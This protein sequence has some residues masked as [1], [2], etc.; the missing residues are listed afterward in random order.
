MTPR[1]GASRFTLK[2]AL[3][4]ILLVGTVLVL[5]YSDWLQR[6]NWL[7]YD[8]LL[9][10]DD[11]E[12]DEDIIIVAID[13]RSLARLGSWPW[14]RRVHGDLLRILSAG[15]ARA[16]GFDILFSEMVETD[17]ESDKAFV[18]AVRENGRVLLPVAAE[19][20]SASGYIT[21]ILPFP[22]LA[23]A[24][25][26]LGHTDLEL[27]SDSQARYVFLKAGIQTPRWP[28]LALAMLQLAE[29]DED[30]LSRQRALRAGLSGGAN[31]LAWSRDHMVGIP[32]IGPP[33][34]FARVSYLDVLEGKIPPET[35]TD[36]IV[37][38]GATATGLGEALPT[39][40][41]G[42]LEPMP[43]VEIVANVLQGLRSQRTVQ[44]L[45]LGEQLFASAVVFVLLWSMS[46]YLVRHRR[47]LLPLLLVPVPMLI[48]AMIYFLARRWFEP[49][50]SM[51]VLAFTYPI[52]QW[53]ELTQL[54]QMFVIE[55]RRAAGT[56][57]MLTEAIVT[58]DGEGRIS[59]LNPAAER[60]LG[61]T[62]D[63]SV[64]RPYDQIISAYDEERRRAFRFPVTRDEQTEAPKYW[65]LNLR[66]GT[67]KT[68][69]ASFASDHDEGQ[70]KSLIITMSDVTRERLLA[71]QIR[72][73]ATHD[74]LTD[75]PNRTL[76]TDRL[77]QAIAR[78]RRADSNL[79]VMFADLD[80][81]KKINDS[82]G[83][84]AGDALLK[85]VAVSLSE[86]VRHEDTVGRVGGDE[87]VVLVEHL[88]DEETALSV[89]RKISR[90]VH[91][92]YMVAGHEVF[93][94]IS[95]GVCFYP[96]DGGTAEELLRNAD[97]AM[98]SAKASGGNTIV[99]FDQTM[100]AV[101]IER[102]TLEMDLQRALAQHE[103]RLFYQP[104]VNMDSGHIVGFE[105]LIRWQHPDR[106]LLLPS[107]FI[108]ATER[109]GLIVPIGEWVV[110]TAC[111]DLAGWLQDYQGDL[112]VAVNFSP[113]Q[114][115]DPG[116]TAVIESAL[117][118]SGLTM[119]HMELEITEEVLMSD[120]YGGI[121]TLHR[122]MDL[123]L[124]VAIDDFGTGYSSFS[125][126]KRF[127]VSR[128]KIDRLFVKDV[129]SNQ[130]DAAIVQAIISMARLLRM[131]LTV[132]G[133]ETVE[134]A[135]YFRRHSCAE[136]QGL[137]FGE[138]VEARQVERL[139]QRSRLTPQAVNTSTSPVE[140]DVLSRT[141]RG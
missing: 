15:G 45:W 125:Y 12:P 20:W 3:V 6:W 52:L 106:G 89:A 57:R 37:L 68:V 132:E 136:S 71:Q 83:H 109:N 110:R 4:A 126:L 30:W 123:G 122:L 101:V 61:W 96:K 50:S 127:A 98:Y 38:V 119:E 53:R 120:A 138:P 129:I 72:Y 91:R 118:A 60:L 46:L 22:E 87:F 113:R 13:Q 26:G 82:L 133:V 48:S 56:L 135:N 117:G 11:Q 66:E 34:R 69:R 55:R 139:L 81:F 8:T 63:E 137:Y 121:S 79:A 77:Q 97:T 92:P 17:P 134:Q 10:G 85:V 100:K 28:H 93:V 104:I 67:E 95:I 75:L 25:A 140:R 49:M 84:F 42:N 102:F 41:S 27:E 141:R 86:A 130:D 65:V 88:A 24:A 131:Q 64:G 74:P 105:A 5:D 124:K 62:A 108:P 47:R 2:D 40:L 43:G 51:L 39:P 1:I 31:R 112:R 44:P 78:A 115:R 19:R 54:A 29:P 80:D 128:L 90:A 107:R 59:Y 116:L 16:V 14:P 114:L 33:G 32:Y 18:Q 35:F 99:A 94:T 36:R 111:A 70:G 76:L 23:A 103:F 58:I 7:A 21:E 73:Q 9:R